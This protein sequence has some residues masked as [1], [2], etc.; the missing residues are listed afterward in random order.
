MKI[1]A[2]YDPWCVWIGELT[3]EVVAYFEVRGLV[4][5]S[6]DEALQFVNTE[7]GE[8]CEIRLAMDS[9]WVYNNPENKEVYSVE[10][11]CEELG[12]AI[13]MLIVAGYQAGGDP[14][15][16]LRQKMQ[17]KLRELHEELRA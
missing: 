13:M 9:K 15:L 2:E 4:W 16:Y 10:R 17:R 1:E 3:K 5:P 8:A 11:F 14:V 7:L 6:V 12:D